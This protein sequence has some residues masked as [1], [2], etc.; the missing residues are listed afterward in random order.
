[1]LDVDY[2][3]GNGTQQI[4]YGRDDVQ[5]VSIHGDPARAYPYYGGFADETGTGRGLNTN[6]N[7]PLEAN[8][9]DRRFAAALEQALSAI[10]QFGSETIVV[11]LG[12]DTYQLDPIGDFAISSDAFFDHG[13][14]IASLD[15]P[16]VI[17]QEGGYHVPHLGRNVHEW[18][19]GAASATA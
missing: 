4:F 12:V 7:L 10:E 18:L 17:L 15:L 14:V 8:A 11:S 13:S 3:H 16:L 1:V 9:D 19:R 6:L 5:Y 2:H